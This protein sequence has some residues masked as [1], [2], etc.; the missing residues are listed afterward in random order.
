MNGPLS[1]AAVGDCLI[2]R[3]VSALEDPGFLALVEL[4]RGADCAWGNC[5]VVF[6]DPRTVYRAVK[7]NDP[8]VYCE[9]WGAEELRFLGLNLV[10]TA[11]NHTMDFGVRGLGSTLT[12]LDRA[13]IVQAG[14]GLDLWQAARPAYLETGAG[15]VALVNCAA[16]FL[17]PYAGAGEDPRPPGLGRIHRCPSENGGAT[18]GRHLAFFRDPDPGW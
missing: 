18:P 9:P 5:E 11:N 2:G 6:T 15:Q 17:D 8:H 4:L 13:G 7:T 3:R 14:S 16:S 10:G 1:L 12:S